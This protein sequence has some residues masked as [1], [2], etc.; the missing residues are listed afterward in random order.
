ML[1]LTIQDIKNE[2]SISITEC[3]GS[4]YSMQNLLQCFSCKNQSS[5]L[6]HPQKF[7]ICITAAHN[8][9]SKIIVLNIPKHKRQMLWWF[10]SLN[11]QKMKTLPL[12]NKY[13]TSSLISLKSLRLSEMLKSKSDL[14]NPTKFT[15]T[16]SVAGRSY[17]TTKI[18]FEDSYAVI[19]LI[20][21]NTTRC[22][23]TKGQTEQVKNPQRTP[24]YVQAL[25]WQLPQ[26]RWAYRHKY[27]CQQQVWSHNMI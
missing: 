22:T 8:S 15:A 7:A 18:L 24:L 14:F 16:P 19:V 4:R 5:L 21:S 9:F 23:Y 2:A 13:R 17:N 11:R 27:N 6:W 1:L 3:T 20:L 10:H 12:F 26:H 25:E